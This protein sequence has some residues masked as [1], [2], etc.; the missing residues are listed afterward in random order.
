M[1]SLAA[2]RQ[3]QSAPH[4]QQ[5]RRLRWDG[6]LRCLQAGMAGGAASACSSNFYVQSASELHPRPAVG[7]RAAGLHTKHERGV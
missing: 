1:G 2:C 6:V 3:E 5:V 4:V 7:S